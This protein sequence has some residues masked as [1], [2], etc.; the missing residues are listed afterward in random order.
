MSAINLLDYTENTARMAILKAKAAYICPV[1]PDALVLFG[2]EDAE[3]RAYAIARNTLNYNDKTY[4]LENI[5][6]AVKL[7]LDMAEAE[8]QQ[9]LKAAGQ[10]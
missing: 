1:H 3:K 7:E 2:D 4:L 8:C 6:R 5:T 10:R 9:C